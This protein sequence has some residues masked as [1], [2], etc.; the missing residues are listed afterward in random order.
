MAP[1]REQVTATDDTWAGDNLAQFEPDPEGFDGC[2]TPPWSCRARVV[3]HIAPSEQTSFAIAA[4]DR[5]GRPVSFRYAARQRSTRPAS[6]RMA[7][8]ASVLSIARTAGPGTRR[9]SR[10]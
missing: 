2:A 10:T 8:S 5:N 9:R 1:K 6:S 3:T 7:I 4:A